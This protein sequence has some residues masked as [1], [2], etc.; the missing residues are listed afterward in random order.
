M[1]RLRDKLNEKGWEYDLLDFDNTIHLI[2]GNK[3][4]FISTDEEAE[5]I[6][7]IIEHW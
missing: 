3:E 6:L 5:E 2:L 1:N 4:Y 7:D